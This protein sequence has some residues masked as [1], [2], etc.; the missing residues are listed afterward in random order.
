MKTISSKNVSIEI[1][2][3]DNIKFKENTKQFIRNEKEVSK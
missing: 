3:P 1:S 2:K